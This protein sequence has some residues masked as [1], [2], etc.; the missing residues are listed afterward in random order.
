MRCFQRGQAQLAEP[1]GLGRRWAEQGRVRQRRAAE[2]RQRLAQ[3]RARL[4]WLGGF[5]ACGQRLEALEVELPG[6]DLERVAGRPRDD[7]VLGPERSAQLR[8]VD[9]QRLSSPSRAARRPT[10]RRSGGSVGRQQWS[11]WESS[12]KASS[13]RCLAALSS[14]A[15]SGPPTR[16]GPRIANSMRLQSSPRLYRAFRGPF[17]GP[18]ILRIVDMGRTPTPGHGRPTAN[19]SL[20]RAVLT[21][22]PLCRR[23]ATPRQH[24]HRFYAWMTQGPDI[25]AGRPERRAAAAGRRQGRRGRGIG[26]GGHPDEVRAGKQDELALVVA[27]RRDFAVNG[28]GRP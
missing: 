20:R 21:L 9:L 23:V 7:R 25:G 1:V 22:P 24:Q 11:R 15:P 14:I 6:L 3:Q 19:G 28:H 5:G 18:A 10:A 8:H 16:S 4:L 27:A 17:P 12:R 26:Q 13:A 2:E